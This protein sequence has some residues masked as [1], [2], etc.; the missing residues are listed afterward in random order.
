MPELGPGARNSIIREVHTKGSH[1][2]TH[3]GLQV[4]ITKTLAQPLGVPHTV[5]TL[6]V[7]VERRWRSYACDDVFD[8]VQKINALLNSR[9][10]RKQS[11]QE[12][13]FPNG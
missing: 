12:E 11:E 2:G 6:A 1:E 7:C 13:M 9:L 3:H 5:V 4:K 10:V 8:A